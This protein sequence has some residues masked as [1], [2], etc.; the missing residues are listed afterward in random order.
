MLCRQRAESLLYIKGL[1]S[2]SEF[3][4]MMFTPGRDR[5]DSDSDG[6]GDG[7]TTTFKQEAKRLYERVS[8]CPGQTSRD[9]ATPPLHSRWRPA[10]AGV[11]KKI[12]ALLPL[13]HGWRGK[14]SDGE[15][16]AQAV[17][18]AAHC[19]CGSAGNADAGNQKGGGDDLDS[20]SLDRNFHGANLPSFRLTITAISRAGAMAKRPGI[21]IKFKV[22]KPPSGFGCCRSC[23]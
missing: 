9:G 7:W 16:A 6:K 17:C 19:S 13:E 10:A 18:A 20:K 11:G 22:S 5:E 3:V 15:G 4:L 8:P 12:A 2:C 21:C 23:L 14:G 1:L